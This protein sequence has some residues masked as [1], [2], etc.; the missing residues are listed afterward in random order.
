MNISDNKN[1]IKKKTDFKI[2]ENTSK[3]LLAIKLNLN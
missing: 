2:M 1:K 3:I